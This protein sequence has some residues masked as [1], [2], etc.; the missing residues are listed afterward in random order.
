MVAYCNV[1][2]IIIATLFSKLDIFFSG[3]STFAWVALGK[4]K[5]T[6]IIISAFKPNSNSA[7]QLSIGTR[8]LHSF[9]H[10]ST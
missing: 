3:K 1:I 8:W 5:S 6:F 7:R 9:F 10:L 4:G 2:A